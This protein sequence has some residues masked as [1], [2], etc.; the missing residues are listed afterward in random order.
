VANA[1]VVSSFNVDAEVCSDAGVGAGRGSISVE[2]AESFLSLSI[3]LLAATAD[4]TGLGFFAA[5]C[6]AGFAANMLAQVFL[7]LVGTALVILAGTALEIFS[8]VVVGGALS[9]FVFESAADLSHSESV[10]ADLSQ[11][12]VEVPLAGAPQV[13]GVVVSAGSSFFVACPFVATATDAPPRPRPR[14]RSE[15]LPRPPRDAS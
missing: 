5:D 10:A 9:S 8:T 6:S 12:E 11:S 2:A 3:A 13:D 15:P 4:V 1:A 7:T 14:A